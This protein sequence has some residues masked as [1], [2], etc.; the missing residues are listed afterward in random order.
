MSTRRVV[1]TGI[2][3]LTSLGLDA[4][5]T[6]SNI[7]AARSG[8]KNITHFDT[9]TLSCKVAGIIDRDEN[10]GFNPAKYIEP[11]DIKKMDL[12][13]QYG[14]AA[15]IEAVEDSGWKPEDEESRRRT[16]IMIGSG[17]G[18]LRNIEENAIILNGGGK[19]SPFFIVSSLINLVSGQV[20]VKYGFRGPNHAVVTACATGAHAIGDAARIIKY[21]DADVMVAGGAEAAITPLGVHGFA[22]SRT[23][24]TGYNDTPEK[25]SRPW[26]KNR[27]GF[28]MGE[29]SGV[30]VLEEYEHAKK[31]GAKIYAEVLGY[32]MGGDAY[33][34]T[35]PHPDG[36]GATYAMENALRD[37]KVTQEQIGYIN[38]HA[39]STPMGDII[40]L[41][42]VQRLFLDKNPNVKMSSTKSMIG[43]LLGAAGAVEAIFTALALRDQVAPPTLNLDNPMDE[44]RLD[45]VPNKPKECK[46]EY[47]MTN[48]FGFGGTNVSIILKRAI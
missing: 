23:L 15:A 22:A 9:S 33:H 6:W 27:D 30:L 41:N 2:G 14:Y 44:V 46:M 8:I 37:A 26:D 34:I 7:L 29:G 40:E 45:L 17:I 10:I 31:R 42:A 1:I 48:S 36:L 13:I 25:A 18:G 21:G 28:V 38:A 19:I 3:M 47:A 24:S 4:K 35:S 5:T 43:H 39:T 11:R 16:G 20:S 12:F 32:G